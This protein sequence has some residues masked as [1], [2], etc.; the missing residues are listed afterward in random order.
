[1]P[2]LREL[3]AAFA[4]AV[5]VGDEHLLA[6]IVPGGAD[7][8]ERIAV[9]QNNARH[10]FREALRAVYPVVEALVGTEFFDYAAGRYARAHP[11][12]SGDIHRYGARLGDFLAGFEPAAELA[13]LPDTA[14]LEWAMHE[15]FHAA[16]APPL[17]LDR[18]LA[19]TDGELAALRFALNPAS[20]L[21]RSPYPV[22]RLWALNQPGVP[23]DERFDIHGGAVALLVKRDGYEVGIERL[24]EADFVM[25]ETLAAGNPLG[26][27]CEAAGR[28]DP[29]FD[30]GGFLLNYLS[31]VH[32]AP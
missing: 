26:V 4:D 29:G 19:P 1:M 3:Q 12:A 7:A 6:A 31:A 13:Y 2:S 32:V 14:R 5:A 28:V 18:L 22:D 25:L 20:R 30:L 21:L 27:C 17:A 9:Y 16:E 15:V 8:R 11:S 23:W 24:A 10:N